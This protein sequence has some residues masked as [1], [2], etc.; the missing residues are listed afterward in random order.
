MI[1]RGQ[2]HVIYTENE[3]MERI[4]NP[5]TL[6]VLKAL[7]LF[8]DLR[9]RRRLL[10]DTDTHK[11]LVQWEVQEFGKLMDE[12][13]RWLAQP[14]HIEWR[15]NETQPRPSVNGDSSRNSQTGNL[16]KSERRRRRRQ[17]RKD[18]LNGLC[19]SPE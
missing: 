3:L 18:R 4:K 8:Y 13:A 2:S 16:S 14:I 12:V 11:H 17:E 6:M 10:V 1:L 9:S 19:G 7:M 15:K 5:R